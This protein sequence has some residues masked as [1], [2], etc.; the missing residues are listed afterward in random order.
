MFPARQV[1][2]KSASCVVTTSHSSPLASFVASACA[3]SL[4]RSGPIE[5]SALDDYE[6]IQSSL[7]FRKPRLRYEVPSSPTMSRVQIRCPSQ[8]SRLSWARYIGIADNVCFSIGRQQC[9]SDFG[10]RP[11]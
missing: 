10:R 8:P 7:H 3:Y 4:S 2:T 11:I 9:W 5:Q 6:G 1:N